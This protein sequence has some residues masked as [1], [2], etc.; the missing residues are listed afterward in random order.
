VAKIHEIVADVARG[1]IHLPEF[2]RGYVWSKDQVREFVQSLYKQRPTGHL[3]EWHAYR[4]VAMRRSSADSAGKKRLLID[5]QQRLTS[6]FVLF[7]GK[8][9]PFYEGE[10]LFFDLYF[11]V[12]TEEFHFWQKS[13]MANNP[14]WR[15]VHEVFRD[16]LAELLSG[17][18]KLGAEEQIAIRNNLRT[19]SLLDKVRDYEYGVDALKDEALTVDDVV[20]IFNKVNSGGTTLSRADLAMAHVCTEWPEARAEL[21][22]FVA[23]MG[24]HGFPIDPEY[25]IR[26]VAGAADGAVSFT[27]AFYN[28]PADKLK[29]TWPKVKVA[30]ENLVNDLAHHALIDSIADLT[31]PIVLI[32][33]LVFL[34]RRGGSFRS[35]VER[36]RFIRWMFLA[37]VWSRYTGQ[38][39]TRLQ[40]DVRII[41]DNDEPTAR[42]E[43]EI[44]R[45]RGRVRLEGRDLEGK[46]TQTAAYKLGYV[47]ARS[48]GA[49][50]WFTG[51]TLYSKAI[52]K[53]YG[54]ESHHVFPQSVLRKAGYDTKESRR[55]IN[56]VGNRAFLT[57]KA[58]RSISSKNPTTYL[59]KVERDFPG[60]LKAQ[61]IPMDTELWKVANYEEFLHQRRTQLAKTMNQFLERLGHG[62]ASIAVDEGAVESL[63]KR[64]EGQDLEFKSSLRTEVP[65]GEVSKALEKT[66]VKSVAGFLNSA[67]GGTLLIG[68]SN[69]KQVIGLKADYVSLQKEKR[70]PRDTFQLHLTNILTR[71]FGEPALTFITITCH[72][73]QR[74]DICQVVVESS[75]HPIYVT[76]GD[77]SVFY[78]RIV[79]QTRPLSLQNTVRYVASHWGDGPKGWLPP[80]EEPEEDGSKKGGWEEPESNGWV[81]SMDAFAD[82]ITSASKESRSDLQ[83]LLAW[84]RSLERDGLLG[85]ANSIGG[86]RPRMHLYPQGDDHWL[87]SVGRDG[88]IKLYRSVFEECAPKSIPQI[89]ALIAP[90]K[91]GFG[92]K[93]S[94]VP[95]ELLDGLGAAFR[96]AA[97]IDRLAHAALGALKGLVRKA[98]EG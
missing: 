41:L 20:K 47:V 69:D 98:D 80:P 60:A 8:P 26:A 90:V 30:Y 68:V 81:S 28:I 67:T 56:E 49:V 84:A 74:K 63:L 9:P 10:Q 54:L 93:V 62:E 1:E 82:A 94:R 45:E 48:R 87:V 73:V 42:L 83:R 75:D 19:L 34:A 57:R 51:A 53:S 61:C 89:E 64:E 79:G 33:M 78:L 27:S 3:L 18:D 37:N 12:Q 11:N 85:S 76:D 43:D 77:S 86:R 44:L 4:P 55:L 97:E 24:H 32:P 16:G 15:S 2:Q 92:Y 6:L 59:P 72:D 95:D 65:G 52:G 14:M 70:D 25:L 96:E 39:D 31:T 88:S 7:K 36:D 66:I 46:G 40:R 21:R 17:L 71:A 23:K 58:N 38:T 29:E 22:E 13:L 91:L 5:G 35:A 50:D